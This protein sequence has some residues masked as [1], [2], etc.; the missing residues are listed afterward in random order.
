MWCDGAWRIASA[1]LPTK[2]SLS[3]TPGTLC[4]SSI[5]QTSMASE[6]RC[7]AMHLRR[8]GLD[9]RDEA[10]SEY[11]EKIFTPCRRWSSL[12]FFDLLSLS[13]CESLTLLVCRDY[14]TIS[15]TDSFYLCSLSNVAPDSMTCR[16]LLISIIT[17]VPSYRIA[18]MPVTAQMTK[19]V[20]LT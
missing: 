5:S 20:K 6:L 13:E 15:F 7:L 19:H 9:C 16:R 12:V 10:K 18:A 14:F 11:V 2:E 17:F 8:P 1:I 3:I 4:A